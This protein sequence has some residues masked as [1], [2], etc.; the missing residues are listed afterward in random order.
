MV[1]KRVYKVHRLVG[2]APR[3]LCIEVSQQVHQRTCAKLIQNAVYRSLFALSTGVSSIHVSDLSLT[4]KTPRGKQLRQGPLRA[5]TAR[6]MFH[7]SIT[8]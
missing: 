4:S 2:T 1:N 5:K 6:P 3:C 7:N 8:K